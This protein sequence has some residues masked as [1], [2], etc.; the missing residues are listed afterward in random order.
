METTGADGVAEA[1]ERGDSVWGQGGEGPVPCPSCARDLS[2]TAP[3]G[4]RLPPAP[5]ARVLIPDRCLAV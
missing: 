3:H 2:P 4:R 5:S 1:E